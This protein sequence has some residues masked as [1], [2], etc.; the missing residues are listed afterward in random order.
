MGWPQQTRVSL[1]LLNG[2]GNERRSFLYMFFMAFGYNSCMA[3]VASTV[4]VTLRARS[5]ML[6]L[7]T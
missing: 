4:I 3:K 5:S 1:Y 6:I 7:L 2:R